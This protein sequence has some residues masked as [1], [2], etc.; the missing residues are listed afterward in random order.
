MHPKVLYKIQVNT[1][2]T[3][4]EYDYEES[5]FVNSLRKNIE[6]LNIQDWVL[7]SLVGLSIL[8]LSGLIF[9]FT[10]V[11]EFIGSPDQFRSSQVVFNLP[12][13]KGQANSTGL[14]RMYIS[15][16]LIVAAI[17]TMGVI[18][19]FLVRYATRYVDEK[20]KGVQ[21]L[22]I[23]VLLFLMAVFLLFVLYNFKITSQFPN[24]TGVT[25]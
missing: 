14:S 18:G 11:P 19:L 21:V 24:I 6:L 12:A 22:A 8:L 16:M 5:S 10:E 9:V 25:E 3:D 2:A 4:E 17:I 15:E 13:E 20:E 1:M 7:I 23:G